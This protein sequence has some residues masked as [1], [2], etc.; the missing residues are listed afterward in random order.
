M[1]AKIALGYRLDEIQNAVTKKTFAC[2]EPTID[3]VVC[4]I[5]KWPFDKFR[6]AKRNLGTKM[7]ATGEVMAIGNSFEAAL[8]K[9]IRSLEIGQY[10]L[11]RK[12]S[13]SKSFEELRKRVV[14]PD[15]ERLFDLAELLRRGYLVDKVCE[16]TKMD[17]FFVHKIKKIVDMEE[18]LKN[19][20]INDL[21]PELLREYKMTGF[22]DKGLADLL[23]C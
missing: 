14:V 17:K 21:T 6:N 5:P 16:I 12:Y 3:Y 10:T 22:S 4:K 15:D 19:L 9:G 8:L 13:T 7:M 1:A 23:K 11:E 18:A 20:T 2:F